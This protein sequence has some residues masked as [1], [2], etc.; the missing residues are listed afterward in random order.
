MKLFR[1]FSNFQEKLSSL[2][3]PKKK[4]QTQKLSKKKTEKSVKQAEQIIHS[5]CGNKLIKLPIMTMINRL[6]ANINIKKIDFSSNEIN[7][8]LKEKKKKF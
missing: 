6:F 7:L 4:S 1:A 2:N 8:E 5:L 3:L